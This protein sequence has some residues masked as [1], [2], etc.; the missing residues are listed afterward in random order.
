MDG[1]HVPRRVGRG[2]RPKNADAIVPDQNT[3]EGNVRD[4]VN[5]PE[6]VIRGIVLVCLHI[7][8]YFI[9]VKYRP[10]K[11]SLFLTSISFTYGVLKCLLR[12]KIVVLVLSYPEKELSCEHILQKV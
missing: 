3:V 11:C 9:T 10:Q 8:F 6:R 4:L 2:N 12:I 7:I 5:N 1:V